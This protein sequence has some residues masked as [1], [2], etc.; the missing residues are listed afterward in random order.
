MR[1]TWHN[2]PGWFSVNIE[3]KGEQVWDIDNEIGL[4]LELSSIS[5]NV[6]EGEMVI[7]VRSSGCEDSGRTYGP[8][9]LCYPPE[10]EEEITLDEIYLNIWQGP[11]LKLKMDLQE[12]IWDLYSDLVY[13][14]DIQVERN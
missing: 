14:N 10:R 9:E 5:D 2:E 8:P 6:I 3:Q 13:E 1:H 7:N 11:T 12:R 4:P